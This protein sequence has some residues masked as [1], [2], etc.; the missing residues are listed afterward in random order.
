MGYLDNSGL[1]KVFTKLKSLIDKKSDKGHTHNYSVPVT[2]AGTGDAY[3][4]TVDGITSLTAGTSLT[5]VPHTVST[6]V[7]PTLNVNNLGAKMIRRRV[8]NA[9]GTLTSG[10]TTSWLTASKPV[11]VTYDGTFWVADVPKPNALDMFGAVEIDHGGTGATNAADA[12]S[13]LG[14][15]TG[16]AA[17]ASTGTAG[18]IYIQYE[19]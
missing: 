9:T 10:Y 3:T 16:T 12:R 11:Q 7:S 13:N 1:S 8:S 2:T 19:E 5:I 15:T 14:I 18:S 6:D 4:A 17:P